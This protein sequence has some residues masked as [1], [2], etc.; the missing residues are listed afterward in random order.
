MFWCIP[1]MTLSKNSTVLNWVLLWRTD[2]DVCHCGFDG[3]PNKTWKSG[4]WNI[5]PLFK[6]EVCRVQSQKGRM[7]QNNFSE[8]GQFCRENYFPRPALWVSSVFHSQL[9]RTPPSGLNLK[10]FDNRPGRV[11][12]STTK[13]EALYGTS[14][15]TSSSGSMR[16]L[17][18]AWTAFSNSAKEIPRSPQLRS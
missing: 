16:T 3:W 14:R 15:T 18:S 5:K 12:K 1:K 17:S 13:F 8:Q 10:T 2:V 6:K 9:P 11:I 7:K 4:K